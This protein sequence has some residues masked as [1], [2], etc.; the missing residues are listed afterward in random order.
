MCRKSAHGLRIP[1]LQTPPGNMLIGVQRPV[2][3]VI[4]ATVPLRISWESVMLFRVYADPLLRKRLE[5]SWLKAEIEAY[6]DHLG[7]LGHGVQVKAR[8][9]AMVDRLD[10]QL[11]AGGQGLFSGPGQI[12]G[13]D[14]GG[15]HG[16]RAGGRNAGHAM[17]H[18]AAERRRVIQCLLRAV[19]EF[20]RSAGQGGDAAF[21]GGPEL[22]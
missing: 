4:H 2:D 16:R 13:V 11:D 6:L 21:T 17:H 10:H 12:G 5:A 3:G 19:A 15:G 8:H 22:A 14:G 18:L 7:A 1:F 20:R 9:V